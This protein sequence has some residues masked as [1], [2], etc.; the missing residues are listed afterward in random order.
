ME[1][2]PM[3]N[4]FTGTENYGLFMGWVFDKAGTDWCLRAIAGNGQPGFAAYRRS[5]DGFELHTVQ[6]FTVTVAGISRNSVFQDPVVF[7]SFSLAPALDGQGN[8]PGL[9][10]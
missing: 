10:G 8:A 9:A 2:P 7:A 3:L 1:M 6:L 5:G 4:W